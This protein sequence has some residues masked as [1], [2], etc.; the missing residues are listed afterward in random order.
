[1]ELDEAPGTKVIFTG[2]GGYD[3]DK[4][5]SGALERGKEYTVVSIPSMGQSN[6]LVKLKG[7]S[8]TFNTVMFESIEPYK[9]FN[10]FRYHYS[11]GF[12]TIIE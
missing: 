5:T 6:S 11:I 9:K 4:E 2:E 3:I 12:D 8:G 1:M 7:I 10:W